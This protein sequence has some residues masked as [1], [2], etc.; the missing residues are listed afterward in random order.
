[1]KTKYK[2][3]GLILEEVGNSILDYLFNGFG[4]YRYFLNGR[5]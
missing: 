4:A 5:Q 3:I 2:E 1:M